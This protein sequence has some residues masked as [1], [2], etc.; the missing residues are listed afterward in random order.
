M[1]KRLHHDAYRCLNSEDTR[2]FYEDFLEMPLVGAMC[3]ENTMTNRKVD[4]LHS[5]FQMD[6][7]SFLAFFEVP[8]MPFEWKDQHDFDLHIALEVDRSFQQT[9][10]ERAHQQGREIRGPV[11]HKFIESIYFRDPNGYVVELSIKNHDHDQHFD[12]DR[13]HRT[14]ERW[15]R[16]FSEQL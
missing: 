12:P 11:D 5:F 6:D 13:A 2:R 4:A 16:D 8:N 10:I 1:I 7:G 15:N 3:I 9:L 14:L